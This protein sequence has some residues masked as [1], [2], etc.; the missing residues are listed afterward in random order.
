MRAALALLAVAATVWT[1]GDLV[2]G[3]V[4]APGVFAHV[5]API[6]RE[7]AGWITGDL[8]ATWSAWA[9][10]PWAACLAALVRIATAC[11]AQRRRAGLWLC[12]A[13]I[14]FLLPVRPT[15]HALVAEGRQQAADLRAGT[16]DRARFARLHGLS[17]AL[18]SLE[19]LLAATTAAGA[20]AILVREGRR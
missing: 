18:G 6:T 11:W 13:A 12:A 16:G 20:I 10:L 19:A 1:A 3:G 2:L 17:M 4:V 8:L 7:Q 14:A 15:V 9:L 5:P